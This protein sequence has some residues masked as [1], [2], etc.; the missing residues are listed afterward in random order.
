MTTVRPRYPAGAITTLV[1]AARRY[2]KVIGRI[3][4]GKRNV[5]GPH[6][7]VAWYSDRLVAVVSEQGDRIMTQFRTKYL[8]PVAKVG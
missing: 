4:N 6:G 2:S 5:N 8:N 1:F 3:C 7:L